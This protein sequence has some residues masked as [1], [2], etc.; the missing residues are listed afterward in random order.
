MKSYIKHSRFPTAHSSIVELIPSGN[1]RLSAD[2]HYYY[3]YCYYFSSQSR[4][5][6]RVIQLSNISTKMTEWK[7][8]FMLS[9]III[10][11]RYIKKYIYEK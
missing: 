2:D 9:H 3:Y 7:I 11:G 10:S 1:V 5:N 4:V 8:V 6:P